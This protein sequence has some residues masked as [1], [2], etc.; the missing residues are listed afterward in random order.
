MQKEGFWKPFYNSLG[1]EIPGGLSPIINN[2]PID[3]EFLKK[4]KIIQEKCDKISYLGY[5]KCRICNDINGSF[6]YI[7]ENW[8]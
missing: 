3:F 1:I 6:E 8:V 5:S 7:L 2:K 4:L